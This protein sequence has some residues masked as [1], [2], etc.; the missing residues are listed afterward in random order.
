VRPGTTVRSVRPCLRAEFLRLALKVVR[1]GADL[2]VARFEL[3]KLV[4]ELWK[5]GTVES[6]HG[7]ASFGRGP[8]DPGQMVQTSGWQSRWLF[9]QH[10]SQDLPVCN[11]A[12]VSQRGLLM[13]PVHDAP[14]LAVMRT[15]MHHLSS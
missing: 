3:C 12:K 2:G 15:G 14:A 9:C 13:C 5:V 1:G 4:I 8:G 7:D 6:P 11:A 10:Q